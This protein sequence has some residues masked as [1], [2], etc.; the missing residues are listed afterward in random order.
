MLDYAKVLNEKN[1]ATKNISNYERHIAQFGACRKFTQDV[2]ENLKVGECMV[3]RDFVSQ[4]LFGSE[5]LGNKMNNLQLVMIWRDVEHGP[6][7]S[8]KVANFCGDPKTMAHDAYFTAEVF[9]FHLSTNPDGA[10]DFSNLFARFHTLFLVGDHGPHFSS[11]QTFF[12]ESFMQTKF[13][14]TIRCLFLCSYHAYSRADGA[15]A[16]PKKL[17][18]IAAK[19]RA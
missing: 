6:L 17:A 10:A 13:H 12:N 18:L 15:G 9:N 16:E 11:Q 14:K 4:Y 5:F 7:Q 8:F 1:T 19:Q 2:Q 3:F